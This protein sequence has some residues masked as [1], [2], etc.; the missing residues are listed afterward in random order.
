VG[1]AL[2]H[3]STDAVP[4]SQVDAA[5]AA[6]V[7]SPAFDGPRRTQRAGANVAH[8]PATVAKVQHREHERLASHLWFER[9]RADA[10]I[11]APVLLDSGTVDTESGPRW[12]LV[13]QRVR[14]ETGAEPTAERQRALGGLL[15]IW[16]EHAPREGLRLDDPGGLGAQLGTPRSRMPNDAYVE[17]S[18]AHARPCLG[19]AMMAIHSDVAVSGQNVLYE[20]GRVSALLDPGVIH[21]GPPEVDLAWALAIDLPHGATSAPLLD[22]YGRDAVDGDALDAVLTQQMAVYLVDAL[23]ADDRA[24]IAWLRRELQRRDPRALALAMLAAPRA[25]L[26]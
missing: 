11:P 10:G 26:L 12:W 24:D 1:D 13:L 6:A 7:A 2:G 4:V 17:F 21:V 14:G 20:D 22:G 9:I 5:M 25:P 15:R 3:I 19:L 23:I 8:G 16:H 18:E